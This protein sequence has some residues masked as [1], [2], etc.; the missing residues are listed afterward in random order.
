LLHGTTEE[1]KDNAATRKSKTDSAA[2][3][4]NSKSRGRPK[5]SKKQQAPSERIEPEIVEP[6][7]RIVEPEKDGENIGDKETS[8]DIEKEIDKEEISA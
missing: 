6:E 8:E 7:K 5:G 4:S 3:P 2:K 1:S